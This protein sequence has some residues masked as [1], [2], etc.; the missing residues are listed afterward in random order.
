MAKARS[1]PRGRNVQLLNFG[2]FFYPFFSIFLLTGS[3]FLYMMTIVPLWGVLSSGDWVATPCEIVNSAVERRRGGDG[4]VFVWDLKY[5]YTF[6]GIEYPGDQYN[7]I[8]FD[9][10]SASKQKHS[11]ARQY[12]RGSQHVCYVDPHNPQNAVLSREFSSEMWWG[13]FPLPFVAIGAGG[14]VYVVVQ[15]RKRKAGS[16]TQ[17]Q[18]TENMFPRPQP[19]A[20]ESDEWTVVPAATDS[21]PI[22]LQPQ[23]T[24]LKKFLFILGFAT[25]WNGLVSVFVY[26][27]YQSWAAGNP[28][29]FL[30]VFLIPFV[31]IG[32]GFIV[33]IPYTFLAIFIP[34]PI[35]ELSR[36]DIPLGESAEL[37]W[38]FEGNT[39]SIQRLEIL[40]ECQEQATYRRGTDT[41]TDEAS[42]LKQTLIDTRF[43]PEI[44]AGKVTIEVPRDAMH[45]FD[46]PDNKIVWSIVVQG[47]IGLSPD[48][49]TT[50]SFP[51]TPHAQ[52]SDS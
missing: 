28:Q 20:P 49:L 11:R 12:L 25:F 37:S 9:N 47:E 22:V 36:S 31:L 1:V 34:R 24:P 3:V 4:P 5:R 7:F 41:H 33:A 45:T 43:D 18:A 50:H 40:I 15:G 23:T 17:R 51:V 39:S 32:L 42:L 21:G 29:W 13:L 30:V 35:L 38:R 6:A 10:S 16:T 52:W 27:T 46:A 19:A 8:V 2:C 14:L 44:D 48:V 26:H